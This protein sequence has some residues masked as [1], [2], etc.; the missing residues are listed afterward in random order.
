[1]KGM[2]PHPMELGPKNAFLAQKQNN[3]TIHDFLPKR[4]GGGGDL[5]G[6]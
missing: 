1:M 4:K 3:K 5:V 6:S 2:I